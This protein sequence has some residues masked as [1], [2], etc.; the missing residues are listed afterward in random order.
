[1]KIH[2]TSQTCIEL[3]LFPIIYEY[4]TRL[5][6]G[7]FTL[8]FDTNFDELHW[9]VSVHENYGDIVF[10]VYKNLELLYRISRVFSKNK[11]I[12]GALIMFLF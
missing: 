12:L 3:I 8:L 9:D 7:A 6:T 1:M 10:A 5:Q 4:L 11:N 2:F